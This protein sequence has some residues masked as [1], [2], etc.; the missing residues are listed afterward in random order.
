MSNKCIHSGEQL[1]CCDACNKSF[2]VQCNLKRHEGIHSGEQ[3]F[4]SHV[5]NIIRSSESDTDT[6]TN[7]VMCTIN[8][9]AVEVGLD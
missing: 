2:N 9:R 3:P 5:C 6:S 1:F 7:T 4:S 8:H